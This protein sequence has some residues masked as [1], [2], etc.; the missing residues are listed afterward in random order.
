MFPNVHTPESL[1]I[2]DSETGTRAA[3][4]Q[5]QEGAND[6]TQDVELSFN[7]FV[8]WDS[9]GGKGNALATEND[10]RDRFGS[11]HVKT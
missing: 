6:I 4:N 11:G 3:C 10:S 9:D 8:G 1:V 7:G 2:V 5:P